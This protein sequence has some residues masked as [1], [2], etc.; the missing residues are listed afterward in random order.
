MAIVLKVLQEVYQRIKI[1]LNY[2]K[3]GKLK[4]NTINI[5]NTCNKYLQC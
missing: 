2:N 4:Y 3:A 1:N 5:K